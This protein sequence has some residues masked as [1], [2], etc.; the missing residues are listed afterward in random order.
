MTVFEKL[1]AAAQNGCEVDLTASDVNLL[2]E[3]AGDAITEAEAD[4]EKWREIFDEC[5]RLEQR[6]SSS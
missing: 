3:S 1:H 5:E 2:L 4:Y 6:A